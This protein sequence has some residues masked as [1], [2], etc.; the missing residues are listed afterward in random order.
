MNNLK[1]WTGIMLIVE[2]LLLFAPL[3][4][5]GAA[6]NWPA[7]LDQPAGVVLPLVQQNL[8]GVQLGYFLYL[9]YSVLFFA[10]ALLVTRA[11]IGEGKLSPIVQVALGFAALSTLAR[12]IGIVRWLAPMPFLANQ[13]QAADATSKPAI[14]LL[15]TALNSYGGT[16]G[17]VLGVSLFAAGWLLLFSF[18]QWQQSNLPRWVV[19]LGVVAG[20]ALLLP[21]VEVFG[22]S[23]GPI[24]SISTTALQLW[25][26]ATGVWLLTGRVSSHTLAIQPK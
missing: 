5:L 3:L 23:L 21:I 12:S 13:Y 20:A 6:I 4:I 1:R 25:F 14:E 26:L 18:S 9:L 8:A 19:G 10:V 2:G 15:Y 7:S 11:A 16:I 17:E 24:V 22:I